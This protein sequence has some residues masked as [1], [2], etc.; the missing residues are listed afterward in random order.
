M[1]LAQYLLVF[2]KDLQGEGMN[3][4]ALKDL[5]FYYF[6]IF[7]VPGDSSSKF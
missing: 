3:Q 6:M 5:L 1:R 7:L 2:L 4:L